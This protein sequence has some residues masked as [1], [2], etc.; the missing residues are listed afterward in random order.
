MGRGHEA[1][2]PSR[3]ET[4]GYEYKSLWSATDPDKKLSIDNEETYSAYIVNPDG[5]NTAT[6]ISL[7]GEGAASGGWY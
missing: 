7:T 5:K 2:Y 4:Y 6:G 1:F 3:T